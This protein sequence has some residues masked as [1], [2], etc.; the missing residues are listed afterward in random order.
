MH[1]IGHSILK[2]FPHMRL[3]SITSEDFVNEFIKCIQDKNTESFRQ[4]YRNID[5][6][7]VDDIQFLGRGDKDLSLIH[8]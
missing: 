4:Q 3:R 1:A 8:I 2:K 7:L 5:V 6:L